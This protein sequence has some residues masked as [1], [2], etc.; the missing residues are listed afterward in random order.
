M[1]CREEFHS[2]GMN[3]ES[4][5][6]T[7]TYFALQ[8]THADREKNRRIHRQQTSAVKKRPIVRI[9]TQKKSNRKKR[10]SKYHLN[11]AQYT[12]QHTETTIHVN[13]FPLAL[14]FENLKCS[15]VLCIEVHIFAFSFIVW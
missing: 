2:K 10:E 9:T 4:T 5:P 13:A 8:Q 3:T 14:L 11:N 7:R 15:F 6:F 1:H 12:I